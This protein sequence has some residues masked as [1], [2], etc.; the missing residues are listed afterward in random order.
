MKKILHSFQTH[1]YY[2]FI[3]QKKYFIVLPDITIKL[4]Y[5]VLL[6]N[7]SISN[8]MLLA[9]TLIHGKLI[10]NKDEPVAFANVLLLNPTDSSLIK[11]V[12]SGEDGFF[13]FSQIPKRSYL[14]K[15][16]F[17]GFQDHYQKLLIT[18]DLN[19]P[20][21]Q[22]LESSKELNEVLVTAEKP[23]FEKQMDR[24]V[25]NVQQSITAAGNSVLEV[26]Q[27]SPGIM[28]NNKNDMTMNGK[29]GIMV[30]INNRPM[31]LPI[32]AVIQ[33]LD[34]M[35]A[36]NVEKIELITTPPA[37]YDAEG[38]AGII[39]IVMKENN[40]FGTSGNIGFL[41]GRNAA[42]N[43]GTNFNIYHRRKRL[44]LFA[45][46][47]LNYDN[48]FA[49]WNSY[50]SFINQD[51]NS[52]FVSRHTR[53]HYTAVQNFNS[54]MQVDLTKRT[55][56]GTNISLYQRFYKQSGLTRVNANIHQDSS[57]MGEMNTRE[58]NRWQ[59]LTANLFFNHHFNE[60]NEIRID[61]DFHNYNNY[62]P[63][64]YYNDFY[65]PEKSFSQTQKISLE[66][67]TPIYV[68]V[69]KVDYTYKPSSKLYFEL[70]A[71]KSLSTFENEVETKITEEGKT[72]KDPELSGISFMHEDITSAYLSGDWT[73]NS[74]YH[75]KA[76]LRYEHTSTFISTDTERGIIDRN[77][78]IFFPSIYLKRKISE[79]VDLYLNYSKRITRPTYND[80]APFVYIFDPNTFFGGN[81]ALMPAVIDG[82]EMNVKYKKAIISF[83]FSNSKNDIAIYQPEIDLNTQRQ[84][85]RS[86]NLNY[87]KVLSLNF[88]APW[89]ATEWWDIQ[90][91]VTGLNQTFQTSHLESNEVINVK[92]LILNITNNIVFPRKFS[93]EV[94]GIYQS[95]MTWGMYSFNPWGM[96]NIG[97]QKVL[98]KNLGTLRV[99]IDD[100]FYTNILHFT[101]FIPKYNLTSQMDY[102]IHVQ[103]IRF[104]YTKNFG[105]K[106]LK[107][108]K[109]KT[110]SEE[111]RNRV[112]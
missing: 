18:E 24:L 60:K 112:Q 42:E 17:I 29:S 55:F 71:K 33:M 84:T 65:F 102:D 108:V 79:R 44:S 85:L 89:V 59:F 56:A 70:G 101:S 49:K 53:N 72:V 83:N 86:Q 105:N 15:T 3:P 36:A 40:D 61:V 8:S 58:L 21:I 27:K 96:V 10:N 26:L 63:S 5:I 48:N 103:T 14:L 104:N 16:I 76:G 34:G 73:I 64:T 69:G 37:K 77:Y 6:L 110:G 35:S 45:D 23:L 75:L 51:F 38:S 19:I 100:L 92:N 97:I 7:L 28:V 54:G 90:T 82:Y 62:N 67:T 39:H 107:A 88:S 43:L 93:L 81:T 109:L 1:L 22:L 91:N 4:F 52:I 47:S 94:N 50:L 95:R 11:G 9:Q 98:N 32:D 57:R 78:G 46:Y 68:K 66:K 87:M 20:P 25:V 111:E 99:G 41:A 2:D 12:I 30:M 31:R 106:K 74:L 13:Q 80:L